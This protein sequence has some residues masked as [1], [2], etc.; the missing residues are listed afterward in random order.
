MKNPIKEL[1]QALKRYEDS[2][3][4]VLIALQDL[5]YNLEWSYY[6]TPAYIRKGDYSENNPYGGTVEV[7][8]IEIE[9]EML[10]RKLRL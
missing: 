5:L 7:Y 2:Q 4:E 1:L 9:K 3:N 8:D 6:D 10:E